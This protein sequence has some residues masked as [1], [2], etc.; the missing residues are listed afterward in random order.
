[1]PEP[2]DANTRSRMR[3]QSRRDTSAELHIRSALHA[4]GYRFRVDF[5]PEPDLQC[6]GDI[7]F[8]RRRVVVFVDGCFWHAC[9]IHAT[10]PKNNA[11]WWR[12]KL[13]AN[14][15]RDRRH[16]LALGERGWVV[17]RVWEHENVSDAVTR[18]R[19]TLDERPS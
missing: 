2:L 16:D 3:G 10:A 18:L 9:P 7:V 5:K 8:T 15:A 6:W 12:E 19:D 17:V 11:L 13:E 14:V 1:M 4:L